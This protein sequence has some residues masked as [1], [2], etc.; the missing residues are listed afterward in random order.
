[1]RMVIGGEIQEW[2]IK[3]RSMFGIWRKI[4]ITPCASRWMKMKEISNAD[5]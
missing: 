3:G 5:D 2:R 4:E 1:M